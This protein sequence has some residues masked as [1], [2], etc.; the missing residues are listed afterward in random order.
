M[1]F[2]SRCGSRHADEAL[3]CPICGSSIPTSAQSVQPAHTQNRDPYA[4]LTQ[5]PT[6]VPPI[7]AA[8]PKPERSRKIVRWGI[9]LA[10]ALLAGL[11]TGALVAEYIS[12]NEITLFAPA[13]GEE[14]PFPGNS[15]TS[16]TSGEAPAASMPAETLPAQTQP[17][18]TVSVTEEP[19]DTQPTS[20]DSILLAV[21]ENQYQLRTESGSVMYLSEYLAT[22]HGSVVTDWVFLD[23]DQD[24][25]LDVFAITDSEISTYLVLHWNGTYA[26]CFPFGFRSFNE[27]KT[28]G[29]SC[30]SGGA[31]V[32]IYSRFEFDGCSI[33][34]HTIAYFD[35]DVKKYEIEGKAVT[36]AEADAFLRE[37]YF[38]PN[39]LGS[40]YYPPE[41]E[42]P[43]ISAC[44]YCGALT[45]SLT[46][47]LCEDCFWYVG[48]CQICGEYSLYLFE[49]I[50]EKCEPY[51]GRD[52][53]EFCGICGKD[54]IDQ[55]MI[56]GMCLE[57]WAQS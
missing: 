13:A 7:P 4:P 23:F 29:Y 28:N 43:S 1:A 56:D 12:D 52:S 27:L 42:A 3:F 41:E 49:G 45:S 40:S 5:Q 33:I 15:D 57:C 2:C 30:G 19:L 35:D 48:K 32:T 54:C 46:D 53:G 11:I 26:C 22:Q 34:P 39:I 55:E 31:S 14:V 36:K 18:E 16:T 6:C 37:W 44:A 20:A 51:G 10:L 25:E 8:D 50:C 38:I 21:M 17:S 47:D 9:F 24:G